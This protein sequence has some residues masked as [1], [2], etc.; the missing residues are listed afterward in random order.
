MPCMKE[1]SLLLFMCLLPATAGAE[2]GLDPIKAA[3][4]A[5]ERSDA[6]RKRDAIDHPVEVLAFF[7]LQ[8]GM[9]VADLMSAGGYYTE[10]VARAVGPG[11]SVTAQNNQAYVNYAGKEAEARF[12]GGRLPNV[13]R[14]NTE[15]NEMG[16]PEA[17][18]DMVLLIKSYHD[19]YWKA[20]SWPAVDRDSFFAQIK[21]ALKPGGI[22]GVVDHAAAAGSGNSAVSALHRIE[23]EFAKE[24]FVRAGFVFDGA[25]DVL[26]NPADDYSREVFDDAVRGRTDLFVFRF[27][28][29]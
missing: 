20:D 6:D 16:L 11:G 23:E 28:K 4:A 5:P 9:Q 10:I 26:R 22:I 19:I 25:F 17:A 12:A 3:V 21:A 24:D 14:V 15:L 27:R 13:R 29:P 2:A 8:P 7:G 18:D 1:Y